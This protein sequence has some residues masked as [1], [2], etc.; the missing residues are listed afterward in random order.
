VIITNCSNNYGPHQFPE[1]L[2]PLMI[3]N[4]LQGKP[5]PIYGDGKQIRDWLYVGDHCEAIY[6]VLLKGINGETY[7][8]GGNN[9]PTNLEIVEIICTLLDERIP[10]SLHRPHIDLISH[11]KDR[12]GHDR[13]YAV[14]TKKI[15]DSLGWKSKESLKTGLGKTVDWYLNHPQWVSEITKNKEFEIWLEK[16]YQ[17]RGDE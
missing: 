16:N 1:K 13:R 3:L 12:P 8:I 5:L 11:V 2:I 9:Q 17:K 10:D 7:N 6:Q 14:E 4:A 15:S